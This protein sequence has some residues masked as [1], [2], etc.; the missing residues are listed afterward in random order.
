METLNR[1]TECTFGEK[2]NKCSNNIQRVHVVA[3]SVFET[4]N[5]HNCWPNTCSL[6]CIWLAVWENVTWSGG[7]EGGESCKEAAFGSLPLPWD[8]LWEAPG[9]LG[10]S[11]STP[12]CS[13]AW[14]LRPGS[15]KYSRLAEVAEVEG[16]CLLCVC[17]GRALC[18]PSWASGALRSPRSPEFCMM[19]VEEPARAAAFKD[20]FAQSPVPSPLLLPVWDGGRCPVEF[21]EVIVAWFGCVE[22][23]TLLAFSWAFGCEAT[24]LVV[25]AEVSLRSMSSSESCSSGCG[26]GM[27]RCCSSWCTR[28]A[29]SDVVRSGTCKTRFC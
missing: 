27:R 7:D 29:G 23:V 15:L 19:S 25:E 28:C 26:C 11:F 5:A 2:L 18:R 3:K 21:T 4:M 17:C 12:R 24:E 20:W 22:G 1:G 14:G 6:V 10:T 9:G 13:C 8:L 16:A